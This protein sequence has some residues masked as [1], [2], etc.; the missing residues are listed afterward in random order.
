MKNGELNKDTERK[1]K[2]K[3][4]KDTK[5]ELHN[6][7]ARTL[8]DALHRKRKGDM[9]GTYSFCSQFNYKFSKSL[10]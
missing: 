6:E 5:I 4:V 3:L 1:L 8:E 9:I 2:S 7:L 10:D